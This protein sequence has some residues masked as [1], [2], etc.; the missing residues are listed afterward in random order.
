[1]T[2]SP[3]LVFEEMFAT[4]QLCARN[5]H[6]LLATKLLLLRDIVRRIVGI[7]GWNRLSHAI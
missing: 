3:V 1:M 2:V 6:L 4:L 5:Q 7:V